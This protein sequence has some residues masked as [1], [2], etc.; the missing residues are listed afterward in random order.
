LHKEYFV[1]V[2]IVLYIPPPLLNGLG[3]TLQTTHLYCC[4]QVVFQGISSFHPGPLS[5]IQDR[6]PG[7]LGD[8]FVAV[9]VVVVV[10]YYYWYY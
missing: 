10:V 4:H 6:E 2:N 8:Q 9:A 1:G 7:G 5:E 3:D